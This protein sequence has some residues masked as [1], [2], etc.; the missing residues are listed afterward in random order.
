MY[1][2]IILFYVLPSCMSCEPCVYGAS[3]K[4]EN[5][6]RFLGT[7][8]KDYCEALNEFCELNPHPEKSTS[9]N[10]H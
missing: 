4:P 2:C 9:A 5:G 1:I 7:G 6:N 10:N 8:I 3:K